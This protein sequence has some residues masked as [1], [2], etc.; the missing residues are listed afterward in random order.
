MSFCSVRC[1]AINRRVGGNV[2]EDLP[3]TR[4]GIERERANG[5]EDRHQIFRQTGRRNERHLEDRHQIFWP[6]I[7]RGLIDSH[8]VNQYF[9]I[10]L[11]APVAGDAGGNPVIG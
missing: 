1:F 9:G 2:D 5:N 10:S 11:A 8:Q 3:R 7:R 6:E 4:T